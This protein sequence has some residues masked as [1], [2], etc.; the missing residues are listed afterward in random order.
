MVVG[1]DDAALEDREEA[2]RGVR[3]PLATAMFV[4]PL[5]GGLIA[6]HLIAD[7]ADRAEVEAPAAVGAREPEAD[8]ST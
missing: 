4:A 2:F 5:I 6:N 7:R 3:A 8:P 1:A